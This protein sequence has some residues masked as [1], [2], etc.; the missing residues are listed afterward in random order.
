VTDSARIGAQCAEWA[1]RGITTSTYGLGRN[2]NE[3]LMVSMARAGGGNPYYGDTADDLMEPFQQELELLGNLALRDVRLAVAPR[4]GVALE[5]LNRLPAVDDAWRLP[6]LAWGAEAW[7]VVRLR[8]RADALPARGES[9]PLLRVQVQG[10]S[11][12]GATVELEGASLSLKVMSPVHWEALPE[13]ELVS[14]RLV[15]LAAADALHAMRDAASANDWT[16]VDRLLR[17]AG[18]RFQGNAWVA[19]MLEAMTGIAAGRERER[20][21]KEM[22]YSSAKLRSRLAAKEEGVDYSLADE[23]G[24]PAFLR[25]KAVQGKGAP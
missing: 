4:D 2:F 25:R 10:R 20:A 23:T 1:A 12:E 19:A 8:V 15:E 13:D 3:E 5:M 9:L 18:E 16:R 21:M 7:A 6:D 17:E 14:R 22:A 24:A 11:L